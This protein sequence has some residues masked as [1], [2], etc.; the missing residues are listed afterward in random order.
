MKIKKKI[1][2]FSI[3]LVSITVVFTTVLF[4]SIPVLFN[5]KSLESEIEKKFYSEFK[6]HL[7]I[8]DE[9]S[10]KV[11]PRP[12][13]SIKKANMRIN[14]NNNK[15]AVVEANNLKIFIHPGNIYFKSN[16]EIIDLEINESNFK[17]KIL[18]LKDFRNHLY[19]KV[20]KPIKIKKSKFFYLDKENN[21][22]LISPIYNLKYSINEKSKFKQLKIHGNIFDIDYNSTWK[23]YYDNPKN[24]Q[25]EIKFKNPNFF[26]KNYFT[27]KNSNNFKGSSFINFL[28]DEIIF[29]YFYNTDKILIN[30]PNLNNNQ[31]VMIYSNIELNPFYFNSQITFFEKDF[32]FIIDYIV[33]HIT[34]INAEFLGNLNGELTLNFKNLKNQ[35][36]EDG[37]IKLIINE[38]SIKIIETIFDIKNVG[39]IK[40]NFRYFENEGDLIFSSN[41]T[42]EIKDK[43]EFARKFQL[44]FSKTK[45]ISKIFFNLE[46][47]IKTGEIS[48]SNIHLDKVNTKEGLDAFYMINNFQ[49][50]KSLLRKIIN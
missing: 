42:L 48:I 43:K 50:L 15:S 18:D 9:I 8:L 25:N 44:N 22:I 27:F 4:L 35:I 34:N 10:Y 12:H 13:L 2:P 3:I 6:I 29:N 33:N 24:T 39:I 5:Y 37:K 46:K 7:K 17:F 21:T 23:R 20:N 41:N 1:S 30:S 49:A 19:Y 26:V 45:K 32:N 28:N 16:I 31:K 11:L 40:S 36:V 38:K 14:A 47:N